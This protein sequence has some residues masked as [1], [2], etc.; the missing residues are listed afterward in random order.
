MS[1]SL[2]PHIL[3]VDDETDMHMIF[4]LYFAE[5][6]RGGRV[7][8]SFAA[9]ADQCLRYLASPEGQDVTL[10]LADINMP[11]MNG[12]EM[13]SIICAK[14]P[15]ILT[16]MITA[17]DTVEH[18]RDA[19]ERGAERFFAKPV[20]FSDLVAAIEEDFHL[21]LPSLAA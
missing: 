4:E 8:L 3:F 7:H 18:R 17:Y 16:Y 13:L 2:K 14:Y 5:E 9:S 19:S 12:L 21:S 6:I 1:E 10:V 11:G 20:E 15:R